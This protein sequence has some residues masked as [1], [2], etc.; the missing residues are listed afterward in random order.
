MDKQT[1]Q[2]IAGDFDRTVLQFDIDLA[3]GNTAMKRQLETL[4]DITREALSNK[5]DFWKA[6]A[7]N[8]ETMLRGTATDLSEVITT[9]ASRSVEDLAFR[10]KDIVDAVSARIV[11]KN[12][13]RG[14]D[15]LYVKII[16]HKRSMIEED[17]IR[18]S[19]LTEYASTLEER[20]LRMYDL[21]RERMVCVISPLASLCL[22]WLTFCYV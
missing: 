8:M 14:P 17:E 18:G 16:Q 15:Q 20:T 19:M 5:D 2:Q 22:I 10:L 7:V 3:R 1:L 4:S 11:Q 21:D 9:G 6:A 12:S 13:E